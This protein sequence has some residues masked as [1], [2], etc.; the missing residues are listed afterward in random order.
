MNILSG[1][2]VNTTATWDKQQQKFLLHCPNEDSQKNW[3]SQGLTASR[4]VVIANLVIDG[5]ILHN[6][7]GYG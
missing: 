5:E 2:V 4:A 6:V 3:I 1:L 7:G